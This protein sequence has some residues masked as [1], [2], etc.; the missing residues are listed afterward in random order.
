MKASGF[1]VR[2]YQRHRAAG[3]RRMIGAGTVST[4]PGSGMHAG[5]QPLAGGDSIG[6]LA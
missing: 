2:R 5:R 3:A 4:V 1:G 6:T